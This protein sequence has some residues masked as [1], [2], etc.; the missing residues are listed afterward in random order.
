MKSGKGVRDRQWSQLGLGALSTDWA[1]V[2]KC[3]MAP[4]NGLLC[5]KREARGRELQECFLL[6]SHLRGWAPAVHGQSPKAVDLFG[7]AHPILSPFIVGSED[8][9]DVGSPMGSTGK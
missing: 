3:M 1:Q 2:Q 5:S 4:Q 8:E 6:P 9:R 7:D